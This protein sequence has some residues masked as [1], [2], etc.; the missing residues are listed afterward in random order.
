MNKKWHTN[1]IS[2]DLAF[3][4]V[5]SKL[6]E[7]Y[8]YY[9]HLALQYAKESRKRMMSTIVQVINDMSGGIEV[10]EE[11][12]IH[13]NYEALENVYGRNL[14]VHR[15]GATSAK[16]GEMGIIPGS[17]AT[18]S[19]IVKG[20][21]KMTSLLSCSHG[22]GRV[23]SRTGSSEVLDVKKCKEEMKDIY[24]EGFKPITRGRLKG[25][26]DLSEAGGAYKDIVSVM[27][28]QEDLVEIVHTLT[29]MGVLKA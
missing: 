5:D 10:I 16:D 29:P 14:W 24:F 7:G 22:A 12:D 9:M 21:G 26:P 1:L 15:K 23:R 27:K 13:H 28:Q 19:Y 20:K 6:G 2:D 8:L 3:I 11:I 17:M 18:K 25:Q 4:P